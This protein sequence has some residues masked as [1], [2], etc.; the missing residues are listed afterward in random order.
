ML[1]PLGLSVAMV[2]YGLCFLFELL[3]GLFYFADMLMKSDDRVAL[4]L[5]R[6]LFDFDDDFL[7]L[8]NTGLLLI[9]LPS[10]FASFFNVLVSEFYE[11]LLFD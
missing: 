2:V 7:T 4:N 3:I 9:F 5:F 11:G 8:T 10:Y 6:N 1:T